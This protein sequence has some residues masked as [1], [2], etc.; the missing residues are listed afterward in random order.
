LAEACGDA[1]RAAELYADAAERWTQFGHALEGGLALLGR[2]RCLV[3]LGR[4]DEATAPLREAEAEF[5]RL[6]AVPLVGETAAL[7]GVAA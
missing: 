3:Q 5:Q 2:G 1:A 4:T 6:G 7:L